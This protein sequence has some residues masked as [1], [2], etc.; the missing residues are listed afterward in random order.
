MLERIWQPTCGWLPYPQSYGVDN[1]TEHKRRVRRWAG[2]QLDAL[3]CDHI[4]T[5]PASHNE[6]IVYQDRTHLVPHEIRGRLLDPAGMVWELGRLVSQGAGICVLE[7]IHTWMRI[8]AADGQ[9]NPVGGVVELKEGIVD[10]AGIAPFAGT[11]S[12]PFP[13][14]IPNPTLGLTPLGVR[15]H[16]VVQPI[17]QEHQGFPPFVVAGAPDSVPSGEIPTDWPSEWTDMRY[18]WGG[19]GSEFHKWVTGG[20]S[21]V[22]LFVTFTSKPGTWIVSVAGRL[23]GYRQQAG[24]MG[25][26]LTNATGRG[27]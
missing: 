8:Q 10:L 5:H 26:A 16:L 18:I 25:A 21:L 17:P 15:F 20:H 11:M 6:V 22:R 23:T 19:R 3:Q 27:T 7:R 24:R 1:T 13:F 14:P 9:D 4:T 12:T 2:H